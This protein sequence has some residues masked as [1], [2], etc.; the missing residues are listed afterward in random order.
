[1]RQLFHAGGEVAG[2][3]DGRVVHVQVVADRADDHL[4]RVEAHADLDGHALRA[5][6]SP[7]RT[8]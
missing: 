6:A 2:L 5:V 7:R 8:A 4:A 3:A 1:M